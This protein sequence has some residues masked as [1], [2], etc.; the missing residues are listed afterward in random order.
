MPRRRR[1]ASSRSP[2]TGAVE[3]PQLVL[4]RIDGS[5][6]FGAVDHVTTSW[7]RCAP[8]IPARRHVL[9]IGSGINF[10]DVAGCELLLREALEQRSRGGTL[11]LCNLKPKVVERARARR[12]SSIGSGAVNVFAEQGRGHPRHLRAARRR[13]CRT[14]TARIFVECNERLP[15]GSCAESDLPRS[16]AHAA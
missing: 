2:T 5:L 4:V 12:T 16:R 3:C 1:A 9:L 13:H 15:D 14:C 7:R 8:R 6:F 11:Y 10:I